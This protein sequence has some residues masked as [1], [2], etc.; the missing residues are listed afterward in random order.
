MLD[1]SVALAMHDPVAMGVV[2]PLAGLLDDRDRLVDLDPAVVAQD[3]GARGSLDVLH[4]D[5][6][7]ARDLVL[8]GVEHLHDVRMHEARGGLRLA[9]EARHEGGVIGEVLGEQLDRDLALESLI[10]GSVHGRHA[11]EAEAAFEPVAPADLGRA[12]L[13]PS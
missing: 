9:L 8:A 12:H 1:C 2:K 5:E 3:L 11:A 13:P 7:L 6:V 4:H 10:E